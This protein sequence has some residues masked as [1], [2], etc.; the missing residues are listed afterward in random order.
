MRLLEGSSSISSSTTFPPFLTL[1][2][3]LN[4]DFDVFV[5]DPSFPLVIV[6]SSSGTE[7]TSVIVSPLGVV[8]IISFILFPSSSVL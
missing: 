2:T 7:I 8:L 3:F 1:F 4:V 5:I 6:V